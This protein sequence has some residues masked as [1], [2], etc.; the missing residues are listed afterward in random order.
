[1]GCGGS[2]FMAP[3][4]PMPGGGKRMWTCWSNCQGR[5]GLRSWNWQS[6]WR[7]YL[8]EKLPSRLL[9]PFVAANKTHEGDMSL[10]TSKRTSSMSSK[11][12]DPDYFRDI[13]EAMQRIIDYTGG[14]SYEQFMEDRRTQEAVVRNIEAIGEAVK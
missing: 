3:S 13:L 11:R 14:G 10:K 4:P 2:P 1:M 9:K 12:R 5:W 8:E 6:T 7:E